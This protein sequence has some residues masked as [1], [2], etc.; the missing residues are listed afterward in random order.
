MRRHHADGRGSKGPISHDFN[1]LVRLRPMSYRPGY[2]DGIPG[3]DVFIHGDDQFADAITVVKHTLHG[4]PRFLIVA[5]FQTDYDIGPKVDQ[6]LHQMDLA[7]GIEPSVDQKAF[8]QSGHAHGLDL[9]AFTGRN[10]ADNRNPDRILS[11]GDAL[12]F[13]DSA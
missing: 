7:H 4:V 1:I 11:V 2:R 9:G 13:E 3:V 12:Q 10:L 8:D 5:L 6:R